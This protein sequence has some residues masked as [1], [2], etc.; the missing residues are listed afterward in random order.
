MS[1]TH[2]FETEKY[3]FYFYQGKDLRG[4]PQNVTVNVAT[5]ERRDFTREDET[6]VRSIK[7]DMGKWETFVKAGKS[8]LEDLGISVEE[9][10]EQ[11]KE[12]GIEK[13]KLNYETKD[14]R[15]GITIKL[16]ST[17]SLRRT[18]GNSEYATLSLEEIVRQVENVP[19]WKGVKRAI[20]E[21][22]KGIDNEKI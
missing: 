21:L 11:K 8:L 1:E 4:R 9:K 17:E 7:E 5:V 10:G 14:D 2:T 20:S 15:I 3:E 12:Y 13:Y 19:K 18:K 16:T 6:E 22:K